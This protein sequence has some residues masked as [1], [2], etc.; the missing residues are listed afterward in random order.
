MVVLTVNF[1]T[2]K[3]VELGL[4]YILYDMGIFAGIDSREKIIISIYPPGFV[5]ARWPHG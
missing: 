3:S 1:L 2:K 4:T 5:E